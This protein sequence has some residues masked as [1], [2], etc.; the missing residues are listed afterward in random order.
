MRILVLTYEY[1]PI[2]GGGGM[3]ALEISRDLA[4]RGHEVHVLTAHIE[5]LSHKEELDGVQVIRLRSFRRSPYKAN[6]SAMFGYVL[7]GAIAG[8]WHLRRWRPDVIH[9]HFAVPTGPVAWLLS[10]LSGIPYV[11]TAHLGDV[12]GGVPEKTGRWF[13]WI[14][15][16]TPPIW[17]AAARVAAVSEHTRSL[18]L[19]H[20]PVEI[21][22]IPNATDLQL[23]DPGKI[24]VQNPPRIVF[25]GRF[26]PQKNPIQLIQILAGLKDLNWTCVMMGDGP[27]RD[28][29]EDEINE[30]EV[31]DRFRLPGWVTP[32]QV[33]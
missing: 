16:L 23:L 26:M 29:A 24:R 19:K 11:L 6:L 10:R 28:Q 33:I 32:D 31:S 9:V 14:Y 17:K 12:P 8:Y 21:E 15:P 25:A 1:P 27:L 7:A 13:R 22:V 3:A 30:L 4:R 2:G 18:A 20:Y 5:G